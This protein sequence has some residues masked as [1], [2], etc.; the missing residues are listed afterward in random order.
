MTTVS[1][2]RAGFVE[3]FTK[4]FS[5]VIVHNMRA[6]YILDENCFPF[7]C[8]HYIPAG[9]RCHTQIC[10]ICEAVNDLLTIQVRG[11]SGFGA[12]AR[13]SPR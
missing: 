12:N 2:R 5:L 13:Q 1:P 6:T 11:M 10:I 9:N 4:R 7:F 8:V 3:L